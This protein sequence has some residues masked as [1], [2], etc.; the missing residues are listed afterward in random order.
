M[1]GFLDVDPR[2]EKRMHMLNEVTKQ[3]SIWELIAAEE[4]LTMDR[5]LLLHA[6][7]H[8]FT[9]FTSPPKADNGKVSTP[10]ICPKASGEGIENLRAHMSA[11][12]Y[13]PL[14]Y[15][16]ESSTKAR[17]FTLLKQ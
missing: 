13:P 17:L 15:L 8:T 2:A 10:D 14:F 6:Y 12:F 4:F 7:I 16:F 11:S 3:R 9:D 1:E 5:V